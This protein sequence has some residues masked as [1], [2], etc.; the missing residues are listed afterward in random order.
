MT[1]VSATQLTLNFE[2]ALPERFKSLRAYVAFRV[3]EQRLHAATLAAEMDLSPSTLSRKLNQ[4]EGDTQR[5]NCDDLEAYIAATRDISVIEYL[6]SKYMD[7]PDARKVRAI[8]RVE[9][10]ASQLAQAM[11]SLKESA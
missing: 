3:Q 6:V 7:T 2:P 11:T 5:F 10:L 4:P 1:P 8:A 9:T